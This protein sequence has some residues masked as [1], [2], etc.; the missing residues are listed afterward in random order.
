MSEWYRGDD[1][2]SGDG[3]PTDAQATNEGL[4][5]E[6]VRKAADLGIGEGQN[7]LKDSLGYNREFRRLAQ[8][9]G[10]DPYS[11]NAVLRNEMAGMAWTATAGSFAINLIMP[12][13]PAP[14]GL[15]KNAQELVWNS[16][17]I[18]LILRNEETIRRM[19]IDAE[20][21]ELFFDNKN[22]TLSDQTRLAQAMKRLQGTANTDQL[23][24]K[25]AQVQSRE[26]VR[27]YVRSAELLALYHERRASIEKLI[28][29]EHS[30][31]TAR[32]KDGRLI[33]ALPLDYLNWSR[34]AHDIAMAMYGS[35]KPY[36]GGDAS[37]VWIEG[38]ASAHALQ[39]LS[40]LGWT[41]IERA[42][43]K[44]AAD[45]QSPG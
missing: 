13:V 41:V 6:K 19:G 29:D 37:E 36:S 42:F 11:R 18:D 30:P 4:T 9:L 2:G 17:A 45:D 12:Y 27:F 23:L 26:E 32:D 24:R 33:V 10:V 21:S 28:E 14:I 5:K 40:Q 20:I 31:M 43:E 39:V 34:S 38:A 1:G 15:L 44:L 22:Y 7:Y 8:R 25:A 3:Q 35:L 16:S